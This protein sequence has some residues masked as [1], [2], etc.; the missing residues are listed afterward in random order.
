MRSPRL[1]SL[2]ACLALHRGTPQSRQHLAFSL[3]PESAEPQAR[4]NLRHLLHHLRKALPE[5]DRFIRADAQTLTW[6]H[7]APA[8]LDVAAFEDALNR[9]DEAAQRGDDENLLAALEQAVERYG[10]ALLPASYDDWVVPERE[11]LHMRFGEALE[12]L[13]RL[14]EARRA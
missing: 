11:R 3:W 9:A 6:R 2:L 1:Q 13:V 5:A 12:R 8:T 14:L 4:T 7:D 10:G